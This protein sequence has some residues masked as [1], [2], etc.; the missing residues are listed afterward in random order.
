MHPPFG[1]PDLPAA[2]CDPQS[3]RVGPLEALGVETDPAYGGPVLLYVLAD[4]GGGRGVF[5]YLGRALGPHYVAAMRIGVQVERDPRIPANV[6]QL[7]P[8]RL[9][10]D[11]G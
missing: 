7:L 1:L 9:G 3:D 5:D 8:V 11:Q 10:V 6:A 2:G 4:L